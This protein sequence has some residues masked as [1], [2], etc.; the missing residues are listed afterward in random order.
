MFCADPEK[1]CDEIMFQ[2]D[3][4]QFRGKVSVL[5]ND[6]CVSTCDAV[7]FTLAKYLKAKLYGTNQAADTA[8]SRLRIDAIKDNNS[9]SGFKLKISPQRSELDKDLIVSQDVAVALSVDEG[10]KVVAGKPL[11]LDKFV[12][13]KWD[14]DYH[15]EVLT[16]VLNLKD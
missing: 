7:V 10:G 14:R 8:Y 9:T 6:S 2:P 16:V 12:P 3:S 1:P 5:L 13:I 15:Q 11:K 4:H